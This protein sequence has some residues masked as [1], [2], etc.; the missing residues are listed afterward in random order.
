MSRHRALAVTAVAAVFTAVGGGVLVLGAAGT[1]LY[2]RHRRRAPAATPAPEADPKP[3]PEAEAP[4]EDG[5]E[6]VPPPGTGTEPESP[7]EERRP[8]S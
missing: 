6:T 1:L 4:A 5:P 8:E 3:E 7:D 2:L